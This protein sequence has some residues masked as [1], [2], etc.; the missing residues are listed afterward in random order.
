[1]IWMIQLACDP[2]NRWIYTLDVSMHDNLRNNNLTI[3]NGKCLYLLTIDITGG[4]RGR[5]TTSR[6]GRYCLAEIVRIGALLDTDQKTRRRNQKAP[7]RGEKS[8]RNQRE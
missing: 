1:M 6:R 8:D 3:E 7:N 2:P 4:R 5:P